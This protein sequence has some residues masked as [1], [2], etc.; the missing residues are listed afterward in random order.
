MKD[1]KNLE[2]VRINWGNHNEHTEGIQ[3]VF[4]CPYIRNW[5]PSSG[6]PEK[7]WKLWLSRSCDATTNQ[8][9]HSYLG[10]VGNELIGVSGIRSEIIGTVLNLEIDWHVK[11]AYQGLGFGYQLAKNALQGTLEDS[12]FRVVARIKP[13]NLPSNRLAQKLEMI[14]SQT[15]EGQF[16]LWFTI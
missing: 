13:D 12:I 11:Q 16:N 10:Y 2:L 7:V 9:A 15:N 4:E 1:I 6:D 8:K 3:S 5:F 14:K